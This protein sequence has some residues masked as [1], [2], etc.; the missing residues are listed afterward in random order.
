MST[1]SSRMQSCAREHA[2]VRGSAT[3]TSSATVTGS[4]AV[5][6]SAT[7]T[8]HMLECIEQDAKICSSVIEHGVLS[9]SNPGLLP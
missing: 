7:A 1:A 2:T 6:G 3:V 9:A 8:E 5:T 4:A